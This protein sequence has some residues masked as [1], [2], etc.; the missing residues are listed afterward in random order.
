MLSERVMEE[1]RKKKMLRLSEIL[2]MAQSCWLQPQKMK[3]R[4]FGR[5]D[6]T[7]KFQPPSHTSLLRDQM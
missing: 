1:E 5:R 7:L 6:I 2:K 4:A 3:G